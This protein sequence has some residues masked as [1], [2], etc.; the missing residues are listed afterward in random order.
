M[1]DYAR[2]DTVE[3]TFVPKRTDNL[4]PDVVER[5]GQRRLWFAGWDITEE[6]GG[7]YVGQ[8]AWLPWGTG[9][10]HDW[11]GFGWIP[12]EDLADVELVSRLD[13][14]GEGAES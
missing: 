11:A 6:D 5:V 14:P 13:K 9:I 10:D 4:R 2:Y 12:T 7:P 3:A 8:F 1:T